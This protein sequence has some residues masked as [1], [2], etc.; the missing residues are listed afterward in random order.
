MHSQDLQPSIR[1]GGKDIPAHKVWPI[2]ELLYGVNEFLARLNEQMPE[3]AT[4]RTVAVVPEVRRRLKAIEVAI[5]RK[6]KPTPEMEQHARSLLKPMPV[7]EALER[8]NAEH[9][10]DLSMAEFVELVG[11]RNYY[12][13][14]REEAREWE[15]NKILPSQTADIWNEQNR[16]APGKAGEAWTAQKIDRLLSGGFT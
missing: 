8:F 14:L 3:Y 7:E 11:P 5:P 2:T 4:E 13:A 16:P 12:K 1:F 9:D 15:L 6:F 10:L